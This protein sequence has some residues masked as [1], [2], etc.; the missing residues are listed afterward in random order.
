MYRCLE[1]NKHYRGPREQCSGCGGGD[2][3]LCSYD[4]PTHGWKHRDAGVRALVNPRLTPEVV[5]QRLW[6]HEMMR[7]QTMSEDALAARV[8]KITHP[9]KLYTFARALRASGMDDLARMAER[10]LKVEANPQRR[11]GGFRTFPWPHSISPS[12]L[13]PGQRRVLDFTAEALKWG[14][15][16]G[17]E[18]TQGEEMYRTMARNASA[19]L[20]PGEYDRF[21][22]H[23]HNV[24][25]YLYA[26]H[27]TQAR[28]NLAYDE[29]VGYEAGPLTAPPTA[30]IPDMTEE[31]MM[32]TEVPA[33][34]N[35]GFWQWWQQYMFPPG[36]R[37]IMVTDLMR[38]E[39]NPRRRRKRLHT[40]AN[41]LRSQ[42]LPQEEEPEEEYEWI[43]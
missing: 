39:E 36:R 21:S 3:D 19:A 24:E 2:I 28:R 10:R 8:Y 6:A 41:I 31:T 25:D 16:R 27:G 32:P 42:E 33:E 37:R 18:A 17:P 15:L 22:I 26:A 13:T 12:I 20:T 35:P 23:F 29:L 38:A 40:E 9:D 5:E 30:A 11:K 7:I 43:E 34:N 4:C 14:N 1:C